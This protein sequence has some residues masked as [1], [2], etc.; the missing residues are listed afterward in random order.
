MSTQVA[1]HFFILVFFF[2]DTEYHAVLVRI[3]L[4]T[5]CGGI[6]ER[7]KD[8]HTQVLL[9]RCCLLAVPSPW[10]G[11]SW[12]EELVLALHPALGPGGRCP[13]C[14]EDG[15]PSVLRFPAGSGGQP[16]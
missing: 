4:K 11:W 2:F 15:C 1:S 8:K 10:P 7:Q 14:A 5:L 13:C 9:E 16:V 3:T 12:G 6:L